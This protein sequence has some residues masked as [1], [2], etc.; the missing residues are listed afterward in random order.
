MRRQEVVVDDRNEQSRRIAPL[1]SPG[2]E[3]RALPAKSV[4]TD[5]R[6]GDSKNAAQQLILIGTLSSGEHNR[7]SFHP[8]TNFLPGA[9]GL[10]LISWLGTLSTS[11]VVLLPM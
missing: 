7:A 5:R 4:H 8:S 3:W 11:N 2:A 1:Y 9:A 6:N 10:H